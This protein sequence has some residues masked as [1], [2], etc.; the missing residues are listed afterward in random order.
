MQQGQRPQTPAVRKAHAADTG[1]HASSASGGA[2]LTLDAWDRMTISA[3]AAATA[4]TGALP[5]G[6]AA[7]L[8]VIDAGFAVVDPARTGGTRAVPSAGAVHPYECHVIT[9]EAVF[10]T[11]AVRRRVFRTAVTD[12]AALAAAG[13]PMP[14]DGGAVVVVVTRPWLSMRKYGDR[15]YLYTQLDTAHLA[16][17]LLGLASQSPGNAELRL[18][19][20]REP[21][22][23]LLGIA[24]RCREIHSV[25]R[26]GPASPSVRSAPGWTVYEAGGGAERPSWLERLCWESLGQVAAGDAPESRVPLELPDGGGPLAVTEPSGGAEPPDGAGPLDV[27]EPPDKAEP[28]DVAGPPLRATAVVRKPFLPAGARLPVDASWSL[29]PKWRGLS[30][31]RRSSER[32]AAGAISGAALGRTLA[33][34]RTALACDLPAETVLRLTLVARSVSGLAPGTYR[35]TG[36]GDDRAGLPLTDQDLVRACMHQD[37]LGSAAAAVLFHIRRDDLLGRSPVALREALFRAGGLGQLLYLGATEAGIG[38]TGV[39]GFDTRRWQHLG[40]VPEGDELLYLLLLGADGDP[41]AKWDRF[42]TAYAQ[43]ER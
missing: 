9:A 35:L 13:V 16:V 32:F 38:V 28:L 5:A 21:L 40:C 17:N 22:A 42:Q 15:G 6:L 36:D 12:P 37:H 2:V 23:G 33:A 43:A 3:P 7:A 10:E 26:M 19:V 31:G 8:A 34:T 18:R 24:D 11:D 30:A 1:P 41:G 29:G 20:R 25:L 27:A 39:G 14:A 4:G